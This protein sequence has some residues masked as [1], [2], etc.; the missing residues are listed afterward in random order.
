MHGLGEALLA[1]HTKPDAN[2]SRS[3]FSYLN[4]AELCGACSHHTRQ[5]CGTDVWKFIF[6]VG[7]E[8][9]ILFNPGDACMFVTK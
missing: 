6:P 3:A 1:K 9:I 2:A 7:F 8:D 5:L 4:T